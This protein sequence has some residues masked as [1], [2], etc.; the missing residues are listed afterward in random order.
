MNR[1]RV[2]R[3]TASGNATVAGS[4]VLLW[5]DDVAAADVHHGAGLA[6]RQDGKLYISAGD[7]L[8]PNNSQSL[9]SFH[10]KILRINKDGTIPLDNPFYDGSGPNKDAI[11]ARGLRNPFRISDRSS[12]RQALYRRRRWKRLH[13]RIRGGQPRHR[14][15]QLRLADV[16]RHLRRLR[17]HKSDLFVSPQRAG[18]LDDGRVWSTAAT[19]SRASTSAATSSVTTR[20]NT[21]ESTATS[22]PTGTSLVRC[23]FW[24]ADGTPDGNSVGDPVKFV[25]GP[26]GSLYYVDIGFDEDFNPNAAA[27]RRIRYTLGNQPP[28]A[29][30]SGSPTRAGTAHRRVLERGSSDPEGSAGL[31]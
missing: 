28:V 31:L 24:P 7:H 17:H 13:D 11:W 30:A 1:N 27:I 8:V 14:R 16:R 2:S 6:F 22:T 21:L 18:R 20:M 19:S 10:G 9:T 15:S 26:D 23:K 4:E 5:E 3:F 12:H 29:V 25:Q